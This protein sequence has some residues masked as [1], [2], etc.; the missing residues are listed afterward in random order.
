MET[1]HLPLREIEERF[2][3]SELTLMA[4][5]SQELHYNLTKDNPA[6]GRKKGSIYEEGEVGPDG[7]PEYFLAKEDIYDPYKKD[8]YGNRILIARKGEVNLS[9]VKGEQARRYF[10]KLGIPLPESGAIKTKYG[11]E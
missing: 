11:I 10:A 6:P 1:F 5:R 3:G 4:W 8:M 9:Q 2:T 7:I